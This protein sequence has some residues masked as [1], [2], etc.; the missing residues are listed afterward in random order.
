M[1]RLATVA[2]ALCIAAPVAAQKKA[3]KK[4]AQQAAQADQAD[5]AEADQAEV[6]ADALPPPAKP[7]KPK[8]KDLDELLQQIKTGGA[9]SSEEIA[10]REQAFLAQ[11]DKQRKMLEEALKREEA[12][13]KRSA[14]LEHQFEANEVKAA[15]LEDTLRKRL[16]TT[17]ELFG[18]VRQVAGDTR[19]N[20]ASSLTTAQVGGREEF[21]E[22]LAQS[23]ALPSIEQLERLW[24]ILQQEAT[25]SG[26]IVRFEADVIRG[27]GKSEKLDVIRVGTFNAVGDGKYL[28]WL[29]EVGKLAELG[30]Q[31]ESRFLATVKDLEQAKPDESVRFAI[32]PAR[33]S[34]LALLVT[35]P[36]NRERVEMGGNVGWII[37]GLGAFVAAVGVLKLLYVLGVWLMVAAQRRKPGQPGNNPLGRVL[38]VS[39]Q[40]KGLDVENL[41]RKLD[42]AV[43]RETSGIER[44]TW[45]IKIGSV[46]A[47]LLGLLGT[48]T[49]MID[50][51][52]AI[53]LF[54]TGDPKMMAGGIS[55]ALVTT[56]LGLIVAVPLVLLHSV[57]RS[58]GRSVIDVL[59]EQS[60][61][62]VATQAERKEA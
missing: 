9:V 57:V 45:L 6:D 31:P 13:A 56:M 52:Q 34:I 47:P 25:L 17:G 39:Q 26:K 29:P 35:T 44:F 10:R 28:K 54:G 15:E 61:G 49:G 11:K 32:D 7:P 46:V 27:K 55:E 2:L 24:Y 4:A 41:E 40:N 5:Q 12:L 51:F 43:L 58:V 50:T 19:G 22:K 42:E 3:P 30:R 16:G 38:R 62:I 60:A 48:V 37:I 53:T 23:K 14:A 8:A 18:I 1:S 20:L 33:G 59:Y 21:L 36:T